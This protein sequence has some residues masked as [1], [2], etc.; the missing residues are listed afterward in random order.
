MDKKTA[1]ILGATG[2][3]GGE[4]ARQMRDAGWSVRALQRN[5]ASTVTRHE[6]IEWIRGDAMNRSD[7]IAAA[8]NCSVIVHAVNPPG[9]KRWNELV[10]PMIENTI[11]AAHAHDACIVLPGTIYNYGPD[12]FPLLREDTPQHPLSKKGH[13]RVQLEQRL[14]AASRNG[15]QVIVVRAG[16]FFGPKVGNSWFSQGLIKP[17]SPIR[18]I[19]M[20]GA[21]GIGHQWS[22]VPDVARTMIELL[23]RR[24]QLAPY[25]DFH[26]AGHWDDDGKQMAAAIK[27]VVIQHGG[28]APVLRPFPWWVITLAAPFV[29]TLRELREMRYLWKTPIRM[30]NTKLLHVLGHEPHT[31]LDQAIE[32]TLLAI[33]CL[34]GERSMWAH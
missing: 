8:H 15:T 24:A 20:P 21:P 34:P 29:E 19:S 12:A 30:D 14:H 25:A 11:A 3:I 9:Y 17:G 33:A 16:E 7:V 6:G 13:I 28:S 10:L 5:A 1:L 27:R 23:Q 26:M 2:G 22:Y 32:T 31:P 4:V 18:Q